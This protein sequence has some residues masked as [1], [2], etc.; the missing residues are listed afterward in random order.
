MRVP[1]GLAVSSYIF[2]FVKMVSEVNYLVLDNTYVNMY[3]WYYKQDMHTFHFKKIDWCLSDFF[4]F[5]VYVSVSAGVTFERFSSFLF[6]NIYFAF[7]I[8]YGKIVL[9]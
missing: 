3:I 1:A 6:F 9:L 5:Y 8:L 7:Y 2:N 4:F